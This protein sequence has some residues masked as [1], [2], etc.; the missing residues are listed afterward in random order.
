MHPV[1]DCDVSFNKLERGLEAY[2]AYELTITK[3]STQLESF[4][5]NKLTIQ[6]DDIPLTPNGKI[7][8]KNFDRKIVIHGELD[9]DREME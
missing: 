2:T 8:K 9:Y 1:S 5:N 4:G 3:T 7:D 6:I